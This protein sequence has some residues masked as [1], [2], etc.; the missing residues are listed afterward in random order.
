MSMITQHIKSVNLLKHTPVIRVAVTLY[1][2][3]VVQGEVVSLLAYL[4]QVLSHGSNLNIDQ[5][6][7]GFL[8]RAMVPAIC[9]LT[10]FCLVSKQWKVTLSQFWIGYVDPW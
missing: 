4:H 3:K 8:Y 1:S 5:V 7:S 10:L 2:K 6:K 9:D